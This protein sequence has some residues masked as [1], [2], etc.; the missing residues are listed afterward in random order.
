MLIRHLGKMRIL[1]ICCFEAEEHNSN[2]IEEKLPTW[3]PDT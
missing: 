3:S 1:D 2:K